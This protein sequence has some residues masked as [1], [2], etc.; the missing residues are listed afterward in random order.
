MNSVAVVLPAYEPFLS[1]ERRDAWLTAHATQFALR[2]ART[3]ARVRIFA[4]GSTA[5]PAIELVGERW[6]ISAAHD[7]LAGIEAFAPTEILIEQA[8]LAYQGQV[9]VPL[10]V[11]AWARM[12]GVPA[13]LVAHPEYGRR[14]L[15]ESSVIEGTLAASPAF[16]ACAA[17][18]CHETAWARTLAKTLPGIVP[19]L[20]LLDEWTL[21]EP[22]GIV[23]V[24]TAAPALL[25]LDGI[26]AASL[27]KLFGHLRDDHSALSYQCAPLFANSDEEARIRGAIAASGIGRRVQMIAAKTP[28]QLSQAMGA[29]S[30]VIIP[31]SRSPDDAMRWAGCA[32]V[33]GRR[34]VVLHDDGI[35]QPIE[36]VAIS[37]WASIA[38]R[39][40]ASFDAIAASA[41]AF[42]EDVEKPPI[43][44]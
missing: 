40:L 42:E 39:V 13:V 35:A 30:L 11:A 33:H 27:N 8:P 14:T 3:N 19:R 43:G 44:I 28:A 7:L 4:T 36:S 12:H 37:D 26:A 41:T 2:C 15:P 9:A 34:T 1:G 22:E 31:E 20:D 18:L 23:P 5:D 10:S 6:S 16:A 24:D 32:V 17:I 29:V 38:H 21:I 25:L